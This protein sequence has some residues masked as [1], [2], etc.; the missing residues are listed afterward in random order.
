MLEIRILDKKDAICVRAE[1]HT[2]YAE[3]GKDIVCAG[4]SAL[5]Q[6]LLMWLAEEYGDRL[7]VEKRKG[8]LQ[9]TFPAE[10]KSRFVF[11]VF[12]KGLREIERIYSKH[13]DIKEVKNDV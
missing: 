11:S 13:L 5:L 4:V 12:L 2:G 10:E 7:E 9:V 3:E 6:T 1:G 8:F